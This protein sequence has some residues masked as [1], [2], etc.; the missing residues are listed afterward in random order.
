VG[1]ALGIHAAHATDTA[2]TGKK[3]LLKSQPKMV[4]LSKDALVVPGA[5]GSASDPR[6]VPDGGSGYGGSVT[7]DDGTNS[8]TLSMPCANWST[9]GSGTLYKYKNT[10]GVP[11]VAK[12]KAGHLKVVSPA[13]MGGFPVPTGA[14]TVQVGVMVGTADY[15]L[16]FSG[17][18][19]GSKFLVKDAAAG[20]CGPT[21]P[22]GGDSTACFAYA[23]F[24]GPCFDCC[25]SDVNCNGQC[26]LAAY[27]G[28][29]CSDASQN[30]LCSAAMNAASCGPICCASP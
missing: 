7:L 20:Y 19:D 1:T 2:I 17:T 24:T 28:V 6:C 10:N 9:N 23:A 4:L 18:G 22:S 30:D 25:N 26:L 13:G 3:L 14:A 29:D 12:I 8:V 11:K 16:T 5:N 15:C 27:A 21:C